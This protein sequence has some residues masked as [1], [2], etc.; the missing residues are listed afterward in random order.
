MENT[1]TLGAEPPIRAYIAGVSKNSL[2]DGPGV[3]LVIYFQG[4][5]FKCPGCHNSE[6]H[7]T[8]EGG[9]EVDLR[10]VIRDNIH[11]GVTGVTFSG[12]E[13]TLQIMAVL[14][15]ARYCNELGLDNCLYTGHTEEEWLMFTKRFKV[16]SLFT[17]VKLGRYVKELRDTTNPFV[18]SINQTLYKIERGDSDGSAQYIE[19]SSMWGI[20]N[21]ENNLSQ[22]SSGGLKNHRYNERHTRGS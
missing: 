12:G 6:T 8:N 14:N 9:R 13:P 4:C 10:E 18:G 21:R 7:P 22:Q 11:K 1:Q 15:A 3:R 5:N 2:A 19:A 17:Y 20:R 16:E